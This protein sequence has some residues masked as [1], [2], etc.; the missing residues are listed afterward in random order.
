M[1]KKNRCTYKTT[2]PLLGNK[3]NLVWSIVLVQAEPHRDGK[4]S[5]LLESIKALKSP[6][7][8]INWNILK[9]DFFQTGERSE[10][11]QGSAVH[12]ANPRLSKGSLA[13]STLILKGRQR[14]HTSSTPQAELPLTPR[15]GRTTCIL[16]E[17]ED[18][19]KRIRHR[20]KKPALSKVKYSSIDRK[21]TAV[22]SHN[23]EKESQTRY[24]K[25]DKRRIK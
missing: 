18:N 22:Y 7:T 19:L 8:L 1:K 5:A 14:F 4:K 23:W 13:T 16:Q 12:F 25:C 9:T 3:V 10:C 17:I 2:H 6:S 21:H 24:L 15:W 20:A 11:R